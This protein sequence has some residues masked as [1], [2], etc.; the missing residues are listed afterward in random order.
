[1]HGNIGKFTV[2]IISGGSIFGWHSPDPLG[3]VEEHNW[4][5]L[6]DIAGLIKAFTTEISILT[7]I[8]LA[9]VPIST[10]F[11]W[12]TAIG[13]RMRSVGE[14]PTA[15]DS[16]GVPVYATRWIG[17]LISGGLAG[18]AGSYLVMETS[19]RYQEGQTAGRGFIALAAL[20]FG[21]WKPSGVALGAGIFGFALALDLRSDESVLALVLFVAV[22]VA[23]LAVRAVFNRNTTQ[24][25]LFAVLA[26]F[27]AWYYTNTH[28]VP[29]QFVYTTPYAVTLLVLV[30]ASQ[31]LRPPAWDG[32]P[33][34]KGQAT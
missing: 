14:R 5:F 23:F 31:R 21:N 13:L 18:L 24:A 27:F 10:W 8:T 4:I 20:I 9:L 3:W 2:P 28:K 34:R 22:L 1:V 11:L 25:A 30:F 26:A 17:V 7:A 16:V 29:S 32:K 12:R 15:A 6:S 33:W 19:H